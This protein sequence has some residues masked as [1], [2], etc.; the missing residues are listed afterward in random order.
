MQTG[1]VPD[2]ARLHL[3][4]WAARGPRALAS[5]L[6]DAFATLTGGTPG[7]F[8]ATQSVAEAFG[9]LEGCWALFA[10][11]FDPTRPGASPLVRGIVDAVLRCEPRLVAFSLLGVREPIT[12]GVIAEL[13]RRHG[14]PS[15]GGGWLTLGHSP[16]RLEALRA[17]FGLTWLSAGPGETV[18]PRLYHALAARADPVLPDTVGR[19]V[20][21]ARRCPAPATA[22]RPD[23]TP[24][25]DRPYL[26][27]ARILSVNSNSGCY[28]RRCR[29]CPQA[30]N[31]TP[32]RERPAEEVAAEL[33]DDLHRH[34]ARHFFF[35]DECISPAFA[36]RLCEALER[37]GEASLRFSSWAR[38]EAAFTG[39]LLERMRRNG[40]RSLLWGLESASPP[41]LARM[42]K[43]IS[44]R[45][46]TGVIRRASAA[47]IASY[48]HL[49]AGYP[50][51]DEDDRALTAAW[52]RR[53]RPHVDGFHVSRFVVYENAEI[54]L[55]PDRFNVKIARDGRE[56]EVNAL[57]RI[58]PG[59]PRRR[60]LQHAFC[61]DLED[62]RDVLTSGR[63][64]STASNYLSAV[65]MVMLM[66]QARASRGHGAT[67]PVILSPRTAAERRIDGSRCAAA[68]GPGERA[69]LRAAA[70]RT[71][72]LPNGW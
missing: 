61:S 13:T 12:V 2:L 8:L 52:L 24:F 59:E 28:W 26:A 70:G 38:P 42:R 1:H 7:T 20:R 64:L 66:F 3:G 25:L 16:E 34:G 23:F 14:I 58:D 27:P 45:T 71:A 50:G 21:H 33:C 56:A 37:R 44:V 31:T 46:A 40:F 41:V 63:Y 62:R 15:V 47:G 19:G 69:L 51:E 65:P 43:G 35:C 55:H 11:G 32:Y 36:R 10:A 17:E 49:I 67:R 4:H 54:G 6:K 39:P 53:M 30:Y 57:S 22:S 18:L 5:A 9:I 29:Y 48:V 72:W 68:L 60:D